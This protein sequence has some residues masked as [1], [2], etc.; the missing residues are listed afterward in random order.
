MHPV[1]VS[2][3]YILGS[4][5]KHFDSV[6]PDEFLF[7]FRNKAL[8]NNKIKISTHDSMKFSLTAKLCQSGWKNPQVYIQS[9]NK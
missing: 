7:S 9:K 8:F 3:K 1:Y 4:M 5:N 6:D 2:N